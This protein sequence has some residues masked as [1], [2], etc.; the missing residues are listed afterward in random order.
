MP[1]VK[2]RANV[3]KN[4]Q[5]IFYKVLGH[6]QCRNEL[7]KYMKNVERNDELLSFYEGC[8]MLYAQTD[9]TKAKEQVKEIYDT[10]ISRTSYQQINISAE[11]VRKVTQ[12]CNLFLRN[13]NAL[14]AECL[15]IFKPALDSVINSLEN[16]V[17]VR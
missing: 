11:T 8:E 6:A 1:L 3:E 7:R 10:F 9:I 16:D 13:D 12:Q 4:Y 5:F 17:F 15:V 14:V 2:K